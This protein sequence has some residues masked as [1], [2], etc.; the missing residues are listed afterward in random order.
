MAPLQKFEQTLALLEWTWSLTVVLIFTF[1]PWSGQDQAKKGQIFKLNSSFQNDAYIFQMRL[2]MTKLHLFICF[3]NIKKSQQY[4]SKN[5]TIDITKFS[6]ITQSKVLRD[7][8]LTFARLLF[9]CLFIVAFG[10]DDC[11]GHFA[12]MVFEY[13][14]LSYRYSSFWITLN[15]GFSQ[16]FLKTRRFKFWG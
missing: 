9:V 4:L 2:R 13:I 10:R 5:D 1:D 6:I 7:I 3:N 8:A 15:F 16:N 11:Q 12:A 14:F